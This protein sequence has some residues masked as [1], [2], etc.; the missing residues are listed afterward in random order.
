M[1][2]VTTLLLATTLVSNT[3]QDL[4]KSLEKYTIHQEQ[5]DLEVKLNYKTK[6][7]NHAVNFRSS[8]FTDE[9]NIIEVL[10]VNTK[11]KAIKIDDY[12]YK[13]KY[14]GKEGYIYKKYLSKNKVEVKSYS[15]EDL[16][17][18]S[19]CMYAEA[20]G[21]GA[22]CMLAVGSVVLNRVNSKKYPNT[23]KDVILQS[24]QYA[25]VGSRLW[26]KGADKEAKKLAKQL[27][28]NGSQLP[29]KVL[30]QAQFKQNNG[31]YKKIG[32]EYFCY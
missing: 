12:W 15:D 5:K 7:T 25:C 8:P 32:S 2:I 19:Q 14:K 20:T 16:Y 10:D 27:L 24:G 1:K 6:Y 4:H 28:E 23:I 29:S 17:Y 11:V 31:V 9:D 30:Y 21:E 18:L 26:N 3:P 22:E 13:V